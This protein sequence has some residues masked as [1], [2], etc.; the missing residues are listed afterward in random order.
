MTIRQQEVN[1]QST[2]TLRLARSGGAG[3]RIEKIN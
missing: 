2:L 3:I 1:S